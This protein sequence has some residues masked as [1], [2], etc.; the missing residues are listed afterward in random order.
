MMHVQHINKE[1][2]NLMS[3]VAESKL[4]FLYEVLF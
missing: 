3:L 1:V 4:Y 2:V